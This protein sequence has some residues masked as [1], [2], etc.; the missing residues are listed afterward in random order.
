MP[1][2]LVRSLLRQ[3][4]GLAVAF[5]AGLAAAGA[6][7]FAQIP[8]PGGVIHACYNNS[9]GALRVIDPS[10]G[11][12]CAPTGETAL[13]FNQQGQAGA[14]G[15]AGSSGPPGA[16]GPAGPTG[17][18]GARG[19][20]GRSGTV[21]IKAKGRSVTQTNLVLKRLANLEKKIDAVSTKLGDVWTT[22]HYNK[23]YLQAHHA[24]SA[25]EGS[26]QQT[27]EWL[28]TAVEGWPRADTCP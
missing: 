26:L 10:S 7:A 22:V 9:T 16:A 25:K 12:P 17:A 21:S 2:R 11:R 6:I 27:C 1:S 23:G 28:T 19:A 8:D 24:A 18:P 14:A 4:P 13:T 15:P 20:K 5:V 3:S